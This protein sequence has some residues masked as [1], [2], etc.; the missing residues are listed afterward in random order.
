[1]ATYDTLHTDF[2]AS[3]DGEVT[4]NNAKPSNADGVTGDITLHRHTFYSLVTTTSATWSARG[5]LDGRSEMR[6]SCDYCG[7]RKR[8]CDGKGTSTGRLVCNTA[9][10][11]NSRV[12]I[13][14][15]CMARI[16]KS[17]RGDKFSVTSLKHED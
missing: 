14:C 3:D 12:V 17:L 10:T 4:N 16:E 5:Q 11:S 7:L 1:M 2:V 15:C 13:A 6:K 9:V 8:K